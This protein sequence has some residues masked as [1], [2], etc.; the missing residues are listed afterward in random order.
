MA[1]SYQDVFMCYLYEA[2]PF[3]PLDIKFWIFFNEIGA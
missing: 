1:Q 3:I 2:L